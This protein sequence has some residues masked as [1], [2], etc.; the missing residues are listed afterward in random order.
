MKKGLL[1][2]VLQLHVGETWLVQV[3]WFYP[4]NTLSPTLMAESVTGQLLSP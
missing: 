1:C 2:D 3:D 4:L